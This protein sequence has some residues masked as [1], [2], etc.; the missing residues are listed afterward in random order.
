MTACY[1]YA[2]DRSTAARLTADQPAVPGEAAPTTARVGR[3]FARRVERLFDTA[4]WRVRLAAFEELRRVHGA[5]AV[6]SLAAVRLPVDVALALMVSS[7]PAAERVRLSP[8]VDRLGSQAV[9]VITALVGLAQ[10]CGLPDPEALVRLADRCV[11]ARGLVLRA[12][13]HRPDAPEK[14]LLRWL[15]MADRAL[16]VELAGWFEAH[17]TAAAL[18]PIRLVRARMTADADA[19]DALRRAEA[20]IRVRVYRASGE[21]LSFVANEIGRA[22]F[23]FERHPRPLRRSVRRV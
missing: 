3:D 14:R 7:S 6:Q 12:L 4:G 20:A 23:R 11:G 19:Q 16:L 22:T 8:L 10:R 5:A 13:A 21:R 9:E 15:P 1:I 2:S 18:A 17:G